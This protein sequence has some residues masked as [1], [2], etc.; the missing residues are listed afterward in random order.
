MKKRKKNVLFT[1]LP[2]LKQSQPTPRWSKR[3]SLSILR[4]LTRKGILI[5]TSL[6][7]GKV[8]AVSLVLPISFLRKVQEQILKSLL[9]PNLWWVRVKAP[10]HQVECRYRTLNVTYTRISFLHNI[11]YKTN[12]LLVGTPIWTEIS[13]IDLTLCF[14]LELSRLLELF[15]INSLVLKEQWCLQIRICFK[16]LFN[17]P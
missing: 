8:L 9:T 1:N 11:K 13:W 7:R 5:K 3:T 4:P 16:I 6:K 15:Q 12:F 10:S 2:K 17:F 14:T